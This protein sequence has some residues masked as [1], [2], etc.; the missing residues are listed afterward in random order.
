MLPLLH[1]GL[2]SFHKIKT[3]CFAISFPSTVLTK[4][5]QQ[6]YVRE[7][8][9]LCI[10]QNRLTDFY[11]KCMLKVLFC[12]ILKPDFEQFAPE[13][14]LTRKKLVCKCGRIYSSKTGLLN[15]CG[16]LVLK[17]GKFKFPLANE[18]LNIVMEISAGV[19][20]GQHAFFTETPST[21]CFF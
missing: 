13:S 12:C 5:S 19:E 6:K 15:R 4:T 17:L 20:A 10:V 21:G 18:D 2:F 1:Y 16:G 11:Q 9:I 3:I 7:I 8:K 14:S